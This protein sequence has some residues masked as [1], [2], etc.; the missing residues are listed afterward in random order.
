MTA[1]A[2]KAP[3]AVAVMLATA[4]VSAA[5]ALGPPPKETGPAGRWE[6][7]LSI[8]RL[9]NC[10]LE[11]SLTKQKNQVVTLTIR[12]DAEGALSA[13]EIIGGPEGTRVP[14]TWQGA[15]GRNGSISFV[16]AMVAPANLP[17]IVVGP[18]NRIDR[19][20]CKGDAFEMVSNL[21]GKLKL[22]K[23][24]DKLRLTGAI[25]MCPTLSCDFR[26]TYTLER[27]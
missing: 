27:E 17:W 14:S 12:E 7:T 11:P 23:R 16:R 5:L 26:L 25:D 20:E 8:Y 22:G 4:A 10:L 2:R 21:T 24:G 19:R 13:S 6:G 18:Q 9:G 15:M 3:A 1:G